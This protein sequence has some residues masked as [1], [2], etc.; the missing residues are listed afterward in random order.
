MYIDNIIIGKPEPYFES[1]DYVFAN[2][3]CPVPLNMGIKI[4]R[5]PTKIFQTFKCIE[6]GTVGE[7]FVGNKYVMID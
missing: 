2:C 7:I 3:Q 5:D 6:C 1:D 4:K